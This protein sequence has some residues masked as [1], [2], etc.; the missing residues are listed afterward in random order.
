[1]KLE[2]KFKSE[3]GYEYETLRTEW[4]RNYADEETAMVFIQS[5]EDDFDG[6]YEVN[7][8]KDAAGE[9]TGGGYVCRYDS[10][11]AMDPSWMS[12]EVTLD[13]EGHDFDEVLRVA[14]ETLL[15]FGKKIV[16]DWEDGCWSIGST[17]MDGSNAD[18]YAEGDFEHEVA[19]DIYEC[20]AHVLASVK[21]Q[22]KQQDKKEY[23]LQETIVLLAADIYQT[24]YDSDDC[25]GWGD[26]CG[27][28]IGYAKR[29][30]N[31]LNWQEDDERDYIQE[32]EKFEEKI[33]KERGLN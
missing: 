28:I 17:D 19:R 2:I 22:K 11:D 8:R 31:E 7:V 13:Y 15:P 3:S 23:L 14:N 10:E 9:F 16:V 33:L 25:G 30:E 26:A 1:M 21:Q 5:D 6:Y 24:I 20:L 29:F 4:D 12:D 32:L 27:D 18:C